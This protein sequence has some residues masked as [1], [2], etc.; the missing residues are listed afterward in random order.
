MEVYGVKCAKGSINQFLGW[1]GSFP[2]QN[3]D[4]CIKIK[5]TCQPQPERLEIAVLAHV[6]TDGAVSGEVEALAGEVFFPNSPVMSTPFLNFIPAV[7]P[8]FLPFLFSHQQPLGF[9]CYE[10]MSAFLSYVVSLLS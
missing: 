5:V 7:R 9:L 4:S 2:D 10:I 3:I 6:V 1:G 8:F